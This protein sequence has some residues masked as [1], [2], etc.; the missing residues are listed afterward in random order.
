[1]W[2]CKPESAVSLLLLVESLIQRR[3]IVSP[4]IVLTFDETDFGLDIDLDL[5]IDFNLA[6]VLVPCL[7]LA[8]RGPRNGPTHEGF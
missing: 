8:Y 2:C 1:M 7:H 3:E 5:D 4:F 6:L